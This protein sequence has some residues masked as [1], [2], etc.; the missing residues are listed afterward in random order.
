MYEI[1]N[2]VKK[3]PH[4]IEPSK[5]LGVYDNVTSLSADSIDDRKG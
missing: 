4:E 3:V 5:V 2:E 1:I